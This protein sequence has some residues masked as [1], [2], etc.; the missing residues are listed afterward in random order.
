MKSVVRRWPFEALAL[1]S[2]IVPTPRFD[3]P[4]DLDRV[5][6]TLARAYGVEEMS[7][8][9][10]DDP[11]AART[12]YFATPQ[13]YFTS[14]EAQYSGVHSPEGSVHFALRCNHKSSGPSARA[15][16]VS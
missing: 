4:A 7:V 9:T 1:V 5:L 10:F 2:E 12:G 15:A 8:A 6:E 13:D 16:A 11:S 14:T 3:S